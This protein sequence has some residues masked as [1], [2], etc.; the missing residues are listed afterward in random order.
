M[1]YG[2]CSIEG[3][4]YPCKW[5]NRGWCQTH[6]H[7]WRRHGTPYHYVPATVEERFWSKVDK[8]GDC[9]LWTAYLD[10]NRYGHF[11]IKRC[12]KSAHRVSYAFSVGQIPEGKQVLHHCDNP[13]CVNPDHLFL[14]THDDNMADK[15]AKGRAPIGSN[16]GNSSLVESDVVVIR[17]IK[18]IT[19]WRMAEIFGV[20]KS[21]IDR[22][23]ANTIW[24]HV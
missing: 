7:R 11:S 18:G 6:Y 12:R 4:T 24:R 20:H 21:T 13:P 1:P 5:T 14:G 23:L 10:A 17:K 8:S 19:R 15:K 2:L 9:W 3:C 16:N 22:V